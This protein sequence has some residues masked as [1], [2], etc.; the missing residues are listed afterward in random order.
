MDI[1]PSAVLPFAYKKIEATID[2]AE[3]INYKLIQLSG[4]DIMS[5]LQ[6]DVLNG[7]LTILSSLP[8]G[9]FQFFVIASGVET[10]SVAEAEVR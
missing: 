6:L 4:A 3:E 10:Y 2:P 8:S 9:I 5:K 1:S 7:D